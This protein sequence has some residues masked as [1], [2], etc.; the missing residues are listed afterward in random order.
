MP[1]FY[2]YVCSLE[3]VLL[4]WSKLIVFYVGLDDNS[5]AAVD[6]SMVKTII[7]YFQVIF[8]GEVSFRY[9][10]YVNFLL[11]LEEF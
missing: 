10:H 2:R 8:I 4:E 1:I 7:I 6:L 3:V 9:K 5:G 11:F